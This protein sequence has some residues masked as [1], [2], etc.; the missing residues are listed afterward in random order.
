M[1]RRRQPVAIPSLTGRPLAPRST[2]GLE[3]ADGSC[4]NSGD[5]VGRRQQHP[6]DVMRTNIAAYNRRV[7]TPAEG[8]EL[9]MFEPKAQPGALDVVIGQDAYLATEARWVAIVNATVA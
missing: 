3:Y 6:R 5:E 7:F 1:S 2:A 8:H 4:S 9:V